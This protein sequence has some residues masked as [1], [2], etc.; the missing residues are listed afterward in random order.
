MTQKIRSSKLETR[1]ARLRLSIRKKPYFV[2]IA[3][4]LSLG[5]RRTKTSG[6]WV[7]RVTRDN[8]DWTEALG[9]AD[10]HEEAGSGIL[11]FDEAQNRARVVARAGKPGGDNT[12]QGAL[13]RYEADLKTRAA[14][15]GNVVRARRHLSPK[16]AKKPIGALAVNDLRGWRDELAQRMTPAGVNRTANAL[17]AALNLAADTDERISSREAWKAGLKAIPDAGKARNVVLPENEVRAIIAGAYRESEEFGLLVE[18]AA[19]TGAR[20]SQL[21]RLQG[22]DVQGSS[23]D[24]KVG[25]DS[26]AKKRQPRLMMPSSRKGRGVKK[27]THRPVPIPESVAKRLAGRKGT[28]LLRSDGGTWSKSSHTRRFAQAVKDAKL[29]PSVVTIYALRHTSIVRQ[30]LANVPVRVVAAL[31]DT[32]IMMIERNYSE[33]IADHSDELARPTL[34]ETSAEIV[35]LKKEVSAAG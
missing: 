31:H 16:L 30:L 14:D 1:S 32:S 13:D 35:P 6:T 3:R 19:V 29:D 25:T 27:I 21:A 10:D 9:K 8:T 24:L 33:Y 22:E 2:K 11:T 28:L 7:V 17:R 5:Y 26:S 34:L 12:V 20:P 4:G 15:V 23:I 18:L